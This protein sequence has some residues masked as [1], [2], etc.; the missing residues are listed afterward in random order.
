MKIILWAFKKTKARTFPAER[1]SFGRFVDFQPLCRLCIAYGNE[2][3]L[4]FTLRS[5]KT[6]A[7]DFR[8]N[9]S[10]MIVQKFFP[11]IRKIP[12]LINPTTLGLVEDPSEFRT[13]LRCTTSLSCLATGLSYCYWINIILLLQFHSLLQLAILNNN[14]WN[15]YQTE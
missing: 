4:N 10:A 5:L 6:L 2:P 15:Q 1:W 12:E 8:I 3:T 14:I 11:P 7:L 13:L 9:C